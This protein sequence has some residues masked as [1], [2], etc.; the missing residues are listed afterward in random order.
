MFKYKT[1]VL[2]LVLVSLTG[3]GNL[4]LANGY[5]DDPEYEENLENIYDVSCSVDSTNPYCIPN[6]EY[7]PDFNCINKLMLDPEANCHVNKCVGE[8][9]VEPAAAY[10]KLIS[11]FGKGIYVEHSQ[12]IP[13]II[14]IVISTVLGLVS[15]YA[16]VVGAYTAAV[17]RVNATEAESI[18][19][20][21]MKLKNIMIGFALSWGFIL[22]MQFFTSLLGLGSLS[23]LQLIDENAPTITIN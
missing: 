16:L 6:C 2:L 3:A 14:N 10:E 23:E 5:M 11:F 7:E 22:I 15:L 20:V 1:L 12:K 19:N 21:N 9:V 4:V 8:S 17:E 18:A 13:L